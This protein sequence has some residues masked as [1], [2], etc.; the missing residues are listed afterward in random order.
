MASKPKSKSTSTPAAGMAA[1]PTM[2]P[3]P[4]PAHIIPPLKEATKSLKETVTK[5]K[6]EL[7]DSPDLEQQ[8]CDTVDEVNAHYVK[9]EQVV[10]EAKNRWTSIENER[11][12]VV[13]LVHL[14]ENA[15]QGAKEHETATKFIQVMQAYPRVGTLCAEALKQ[16]HVDLEALKKALGDAY[17]AARILE[18]LYRS[19]SRKLKEE[20]KKFY[21]LLSEKSNE[22]TALSNKIAILESALTNASNA[23][24][25]DQI[26]KLAGEIAEKSTEISGLHKQMDETTN[27][28]QAALNEADVLRKAATKHAVELKELENASREAKAEASRLREQ[29]EERKGS[30]SVAQE[31]SRELKRKL[32]EANQQVASM[33]QKTAQGASEL[34]KVQGALQKAEKEL[35]EL[36]PLKGEL[37]LTGANLESE[38]EAVKKAERQITLIEQEMSQVRQ[39]AE[40]AQKALEQAL[41]EVKVVSS[42]KGSIAKLERDLKNKDATLK[43]VEQDRDS[44][45]NKINEAFNEKA[46]I[47]AELNE[48]K[49]AREE[50]QNLLEACKRELIEYMSKDSSASAVLNQMTAKN[51]ELT[52]ELSRSRKATTDANL[53]VG[54]I[55]RLSISDS[56]AD[57]IL[58]ETLVEAEGLTIN[59]AGAHTWLGSITGLAPQGI[60]GTASAY[61]QA[62]SI[63]TNSLTYGRIAYCDLHAF[64]ITISS[65]QSESTV[66]VAVLILK[67]TITA[68]IKKLTARS[69]LL[70]KGEAMVICRALELLCR[71]MPSGGNIV[72]IT[73]W[74]SFSGD[75]RLVG[76]DSCL[77]GALYDWLSGALHDRNESL[78]FAIKSRGGVFVRGSTALRD[79]KYFIVAD[80]ENLLL[81][82]AKADD[83][84]SSVHWFSPDRYRINRLS[85][86]FDVELVVDD[87]PEKGASWTRR[88]T[89]DEL[90]DV[91]AVLEAALDRCFMQE[92]GTAPVDWSE[93]E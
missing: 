48:A 7:E 83:K 2:G 23:A 18:K 42:L 14:S 11:Q 32:D 43:N 52:N 77:L 12:R 40:K 37:S 79:N 21:D 1:P 90:A 8:L 87:F 73:D 3:A 59:A 55:S 10:E 6:K 27:K 47:D 45:K 68:R 25:K 31:D 60:T 56:E 4:A 78:T 44:W 20:A 69:D 76:R 85:P 46:R 41:E 57:N 65:M 66:A 80:K 26:S 16:E 9:R 19:V 70:K 22:K 39:D 51:T 93:V 5:I 82:E 75:L 63:M 17:D 53:L 33:N 64:A 62:A 92:E 54:R 84:D 71:I 15:E 29:L 67:R 34:L 35:A 81:C 49:T 86:S 28:W 91:G 24:D 38:K 58:R 30:L 50:A 72:E 36:Q 61:A 74:I 89:V 88:W 13:K